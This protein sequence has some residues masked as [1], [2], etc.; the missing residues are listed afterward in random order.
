MATTKRTD[1]LDG[2]SYILGE[3]CSTKLLL[4]KNLIFTLVVPGTIGVYVPLFI[5]RGQAPVSGAW[6][7]I[8]AAVL[9]AGGT[10]YAWCVWNFT[11]VGR[12][13][14][15]PVDAPKKLVTRGPYRFARNPMYVGVLAVILGWAMLFQSTAILRYAFAVALCCHL[16]VV[17]WEEPHLR[18]AFGVEYENYCGRVGRWL[19]KR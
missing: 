7:A 4:L 3:V 11:V 5:A 13:T 12:G 14:P 6:L 15:A 2:M 8:A 10:L 9:A 19:P 16:F 1:D 18:R 17:L